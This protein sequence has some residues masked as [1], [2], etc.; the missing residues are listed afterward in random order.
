MQVAGMCRPQRHVQH[1]QQEGLQQ[2]LAEKGA[3]QEQ[4]NLPRLL[5][6]L[7]YIQSMDPSRS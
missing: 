3:N 5:S 7:I 4:A 1:M 2:L 6:A